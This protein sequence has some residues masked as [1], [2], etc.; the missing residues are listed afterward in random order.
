MFNFFR[1]NKNTSNEVTEK[2]NPKVTEIMVRYSYEFIDDVPQSERTPCNEF[3][4]SIMEMDKFYSR[5]DIEDLSKIMGYSV[6]DR[7][8]FYI[9]KGDKND[10]GE[11]IEHLYIDK[12]G[13]EHHHCRHEW[14]PNVVTKK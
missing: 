6:W 9:D 5:S 12:D 4:E 3:C 13:V 2:T 11:P 8:G 7:R 1:K 10:K 14:K